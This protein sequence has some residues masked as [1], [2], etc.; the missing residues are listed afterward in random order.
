MSKFALPFF[1][2]VSGKLFGV[3]QGL[4]GLQ[5]SEMLN[6][7]KLKGEDNSTFTISDSVVYSK[8]SNIVQLKGDAQVRRV[9][10]IV[11][12]DSIKYNLKSG[13]VHALG[14]V[15]LLNDGN[16]IATPSL[17]Y[18]VNKKTG[19][20]EEVEYRLSNGGLGTSDRAELLD[21]NH[22]QLGKTIFS[23]C[24]CDSKFWYIKA[25]QIDVYKDEN[26]IEAK[27]G[28]LYIKDFP[29]LWSPYL[30]FPLRKERRSGFLTP[31]LSSTSRSGLG[32]TIPYFWNISPNMDLTLY[33]QYFSK[34][35]FQ[36]GTEFRYLKPN[37]SGVYKLSYLPRDSERKDSRWAISLSHTHKLGS[38]LGFDFSLSG[39]IRAASDSDYFRDLSNLQNYQES[40]TFLPKNLS[41][42]FTNNSTIKGF[43]GVTK[44]QSLHDLTS[45]N[46]DKH[47]YYYTYERLPELK[48]E[49]NWYDIGGF[50]ISTK[51]S[52]INFK[53]QKN[54]VWPHHPLAP[55][56]SRL[57][58]YTKVTYPIERAGWY[59]KPS[60]GLHLSHYH[61]NWHTNYDGKGV[62]Y[63][64]QSGRQIDSISRVLPIYSVDAGMIFERKTSL[65]GK[66]KYQTLEPRLYYVHIPY[67]DQS[68]IPIFDTSITYLNFAT[69]Y[70]ENIFSGGWD[71]INNA[72]NLT[73]GL[74]SRWFDEG[75]G[76]ERLSVQLAQKF[77]FTK[78][79]VSI[80][81]NQRLRKLKKSEILANI[82]T[83][84]TDT[85][86]IQ[87]GWQLDSENKLTSSQT[88]L[89]I[90]WFPKRLANLSLTY[91]YQ[92]DPFYYN[93]KGKRLR[94]IYQLKGKENIS[95]AAQWPLSKKVFAVGR[96]DYSIRESRTTQSI[97]GLEYKDNCCFSSRL[98]LQRYAV[99]AAKSNTAI[100]FQLELNGLG[101]V[102]PDPLGLLRSS[103]PGYRKIVTPSPEIS[104]FERYE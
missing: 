75:S 82:A 47:I 60:I 91:R 104:P 95:I 73:V 20:S 13:E 97:L 71:R 80:S 52:Y 39:N 48:I 51:L 43:L 22:L 98:V 44:Y 94:D 35:G 19:V 88:Y 83:S 27:N 87:A 53:F 7:T 30:T 9:D 24:N 103:I 29:V 93:E 84:L 21:E 57:S 99:S 50:D 67:K 46:S 16:F 69:A 41:L 89:S 86:K 18:N 62:N 85:L 10:S 2:L 54:I 65:F 100:Y 68:D 23:L 12:A 14:N 70:S 17:K 49:G 77:Y 92:K 11:K 15:R 25:S 3:E 63:Y 42:N 76:K 56:G 101:S 32:F 28:S 96:W 1:V 59:I 37:Y 79:K 34:R 90:N 58:S 26:K 74:T 72:N 40:K 5:L 4:Y 81:N 64:A 38:F 66:P 78:Q 8:N 61:T 31:T 55:D 45:E 6:E 36:L 102:G 33:P